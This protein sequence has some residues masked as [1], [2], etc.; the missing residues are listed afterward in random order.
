MDVPQGRV[1]RRRVRHG[2][3]LRVGRRPLLH[4]PQQA[5]QAGAKGESLLHTICSLWHNIQ[6]LI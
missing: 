5:H 1:R 4:G 6:F 3:D 2:Q